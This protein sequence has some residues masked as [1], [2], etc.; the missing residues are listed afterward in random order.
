MAH[1]GIIMGVN[2]GKTPPDDVLKLILAKYKTCTSLAMPD[3]GKVE[4]LADNGSPPLD[5]PKSLK[6]NLADFNDYNLI[7]YAGSHEADYHPDDLQ[8]YPLLEDG[9]AEPK[10]L[11]SAFAIGDFSQYHKTD[12]T[13]ADAFY[14]MRELRE[15]TEETYKDVLE[16]K[17]EGVDTLD[18][19]LKE[20]QS[21][22]FRKLVQA[23]MAK[24][25][26]CVLAGN[27]QYFSYQ[28]DNPHFK[29]SDW[30]W[31]SHD[32]ALDLLVATPAT[33]VAGKKPSASE[34]IAARKAEEAAA[35][36]GGT[37]ASVP[38]VPETKTD[39]KIPPT[40][41]KGTDL[42]TYMVPIPPKLRGKAK[43]KWLNLHCGKN[44]PKGEA[45]DK[46]FLT[47]LKVFPASL[48]LPNSP[49]RRAIEAN[50]ME[51]ALSASVTPDIEA[52]NDKPEDEEPD[53]IG[54]PTEIPA[55]VP[56][57]QKAT[58]NE[59]WTKIALVD[60]D[61]LQEV[62]KPVPS[63]FQQTGITLEDF[64]RWPF[65]TKRNF[66][67][68]FSG[69]TA[70]VAFVSLCNKLIE[71]DPNLLKLTDKTDD[72]KPTEKKLSASERIA[73]RKAGTM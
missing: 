53:V 16:Q 65:K 13:H 41:G 68:E 43:K 30:G 22:S 62:E 23:M 54:V 56:P 5:G 70:A 33:A 45:T 59:K 51:A 27:G 58:L 50:N 26:I 15:L 12:N 52:D 35:A 63:F 9:A 67:V 72:K 11:I 42:A 20:M 2:K 47:N 38:P 19:L 17:V 34:R 1:Q 8:P 28:K 57:Q 40:A 49:I 39:T 71:L 64:I 55:V 6:A 46:N 32:P 7:I 3:N 29:N 18:Q 60:A 21:A 69:T 66:S 10:L 36:A 44:R 31:L 14:A 24:G 37:K 4:F 25:Q 48:L 61:K 73:A